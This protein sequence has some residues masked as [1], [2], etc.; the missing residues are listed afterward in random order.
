M[1]YAI[2]IL[3]VNGRDRWIGRYST[4]ERL[5]MVELRTMKARWRQPVLRTGVA[6][7]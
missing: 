5:V 1:K 2:E 4:E 3:G 7:G 6:S